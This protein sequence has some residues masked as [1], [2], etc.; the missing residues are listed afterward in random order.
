MLLAF[1]SIMIRLLITVTSQW[2]RRRLRSLASRMFVQPF[3][4]AQIKENDKPCV[5]GLFNRNPPVTDGFPSQRAT[6]AENVSIW[7]CHHAALLLTCWWDHYLPIG[8]CAGQTRRLMPPARLGWDNCLRSR[9]SLWCIFFLHGPF[10]FSS[11]HSRGSRG[12]PGLWS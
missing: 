2:E 1:H 10:Y 8:Q 7:W 5:T 11:H 12:L 3:V 6:K 4:Q 9:E